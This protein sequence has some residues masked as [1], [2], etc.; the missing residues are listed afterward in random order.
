MAENYGG[1]SLAARLGGQVG[2]GVSDF[3]G[4]K[5]EALAHE[6]A[7]RLL[8]QKYQNFGL[9]PKLAQT[10]ATLPPELQKSALQNLPALQQLS[11]QQMMGQPGL[12]QQAQMQPELGQQGPQQLPQ[13]QQGQPGQENPW[14]N[15]FTSPHEKR[16]NEKLG[17][18]K[19][20]LEL[21]REAQNVKTSKD[22]RDFLTPINKTA[23]DAEK[24]ILDYKAVKQ[25]AKKG[26]IRSGNAHNLMTKLRIEGF[27][28]NLDT[29]LAGKFLSRLGTNAGSAYGPG[30]NLTN[31]LEQSYMRTLPT[32]WNTP[33]GMYNIAGI[34]EKLD[35]KPIVYRNA[36]NEIIRENNGKVPYDIDQRA[37]ERSQDQLDKLDN[38]ALEIAANPQK[39][40]NQHE[41]LPPASEYSGK[42]ARDTVTGQIYR[43]DGKKWIKE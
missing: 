8:G 13:M 6:R 10:I 41:T 3:F 11:Q 42:R 7:N 43:S 17:I 18:S 40:S 30:V 12:G 4:Q 25:L 29:Q 38:E 39:F 2:A 31:F 33:E 37:R 36:V 16:E 23:H 34:L 15:I 35:E 14:A 21:A 22:A 24:N 5:L 19:E 26:D 27:N 20:K 28:Q 1:E 9:S 32:L